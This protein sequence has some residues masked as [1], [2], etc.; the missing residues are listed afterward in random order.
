MVEAYSENSPSSHR[1]GSFQTVFLLGNFASPSLDLTLAMLAP[2]T[3]TRTSPLS[4]ITEAGAAWVK[5]R[6]AWLVLPSIFT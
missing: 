2:Q 5:N 3:D 6:C 1:K 4:K